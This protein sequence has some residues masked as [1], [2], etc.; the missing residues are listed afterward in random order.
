MDS[1]TVTELARVRRLTK[2]GE[3]AAIRERS[4]L[5]LA[6]LARAVGVH[7]STLWRW[8]TNGRKPRGEKAA[9]YLATL[10]A[11]KRAQ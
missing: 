7:P 5:S 1:T 9:R 8:E 11:L 10:D 2:S 4:G 3:A 6:E